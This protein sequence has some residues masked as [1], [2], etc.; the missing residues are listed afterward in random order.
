MPTKRRGRPE[1][2]KP[3]YNITYKELGEY[4]GDKAVIQVSTK[5]MELVMGESVNNESKELINDSKPIKKNLIKEDKSADENKISFTLWETD[6][7]TGKY[8][9][10]ATN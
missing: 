9:E 5:Q 1:G 10:K 3:L 7:R 2:Y 8:I 4:F 6:K